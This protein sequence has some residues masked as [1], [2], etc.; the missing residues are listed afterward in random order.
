MSLTTDELI[1]IVDEQTGTTV[2]EEITELFLNHRNLMSLRNVNLCINLKKL[3]V[4]FNKIVSISPITT[5]IHLESLNICGNNI[6]DLEGLERLQSLRIFRAAGNKIEKLSVFEKLSN[7]QE[8]WLHDNNIRSSEIKHLRH[9]TNLERLTL[10]KNDIDVDSDHVVNVLCSLPKLR[11]FNG[12]RFNRD[13]LLDPQSPFKISLLD[14]DDEVDVQES[15]AIN[16]DFSSLE[17]EFKT[18]QKALP[19]AKYLSSENKAGFALDLSDVQKP[20]QRRVSTPRLGKFKRYSNGQMAAQFFQDGTAKVYYNNGKTAIVT[21]CDDYFLMQ[22]NH[23]NGS[24]ALSSLPNGSFVAKGSNG[25]DLL[26]YTEGQSLTYRHNAK[27]DWT[28][29]NI[30]LEN[31]PPIV[32]SQFMILSVTK[33]MSPIIYFSM[34]SFSCVIHCGHSTETEELPNWAFKKFKDMKKSK[35][36][37]PHLNSK[38]KLNSSRQNLFEKNDISSQGN[39]LF[40]TD[41]QYSNESFDESITDNISFEHSSHETNVDLD[42]PFVQDTRPSSVKYEPPKD[43]LNESTMA[44]L[45]QESLRLDEELLRLRNRAD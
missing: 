43:R 23:K 37:K 16:P 31:V 15:N 1:K 39:I 32:L 30:E 44:S 9:C 36:A 7:I 28:N 41:S 3:D 26:V 13:Q 45:E 4:S 19:S 42:A 5:L 38:T 2:L 11:G 17:D 6:F 29:L 14:S 10:N 25:R 35:F 21:Y 27:D 24:S 8:L 18:P 12:S 33:E 40:N 22:A 34:E 20:Y